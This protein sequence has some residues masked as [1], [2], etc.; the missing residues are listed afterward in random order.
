M[1]IIHC[2]E[3]GRE[4][5]EDV[6]ACIRCGASS[7][8]VQEERFALVL[9]SKNMDY[10]GLLRLV[11]VEASLEDREQAEALLS[12]PPVLLRRGLTRSEALSFLKRL[13]SRATMKLV[14]DGGETES[15]LL[16]A[17]EVSQTS[18]DGRSRER[19]LWKWW[20]GL[21]V[22]G[23]L[24]LMWCAPVF[25]KWLESAYLLRVDGGMWVGY[26]FVFYAFMTAG[27]QLTGLLFAVG[28]TVLFFRKVL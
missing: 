2:P 15:E 7:K 25:G 17:P 20:S 16:S 8:Q 11:Q 22:F 12:A 14:R 28:G 13:G 1:P 18:L 26:L 27:I 10:E 3:C 9:L 23:G 24:L 19:V 5:S 21:S 6:V 4:V